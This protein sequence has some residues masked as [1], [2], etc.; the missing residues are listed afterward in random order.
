MIRGG[1]GSGGEPDPA[2]AK[3]LEALAL[4]PLRD[5]ADPVQVRRKDGQADRPLEAGGIGN[6]MPEHRRA[7][8]ADVIGATFRELDLA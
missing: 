3:A 4:P 7:G 1:S 5:Q 8:R 2:L 6:R